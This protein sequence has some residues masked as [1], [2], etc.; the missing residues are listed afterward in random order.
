M[1]IRSL[2]LKG[3]WSP[4]EISHLRQILEPLPDAWIES[5]PSIKSIIRRDVLRDA[6]PEAPGHSKYEPD[7]AA[8]VVFDKGV[9]HD[10]KLDPEQF[11]RSVCHEL[12]HAILTSKP[13]II[14]RWSAQTRGDG[15]VDE[16]A[17][18]NPEEDFCDT[19]SEFFIH[20]KKTN[21]VTPKK[22][23]FI[24]LL[25]DDSGREKIAMHFLN[26][27]TD[28]MTKIA[29]GGMGMLARRAASGGMSAGKMK[30]LKG[31]ALA[32][33]GGTAGAVAGGRSGKKS[34]YSEGTSDVMG[35]AQRARLIGRREGV[36]AYHQ[37]LMK[38][39]GGAGKKR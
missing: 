31:A 13:D 23:E 27:F 15:F 39:Q 33:A 28:E 32:G 3:K 8:I 36:M 34:G 37:A 2:E 21:Q 17:K 30:A 6:P 24:Q 25:L 1:K 10:G 19:F 35:V 22:A 16:Y 38:H 11:K 18:T 20:N 4:Q 7:I 9:Y 29:R 14:K 12:G 26:G 5:N